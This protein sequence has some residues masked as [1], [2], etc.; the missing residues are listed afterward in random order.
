VRAF[1]KKNL[2][3]VGQVNFLFLRKSFRPQTRTNTKRIK[4]KEF[5]TEDTE[6]H[7]VHR[8]EE[9]EFYYEPHEQ[10]IFFTAEPQLSAKRVALEMRSFPLDDAD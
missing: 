10:K 3:G 2:H 8:G 6:V 5:H 7:R 1:L 9:E 4:D